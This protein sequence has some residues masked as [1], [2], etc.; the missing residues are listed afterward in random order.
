MTAKL[1]NEKGNILHRSSFRPVTKD[2]MGDPKER[3][4]RDTFDRKINPWPEYDI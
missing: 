3:E 2:E 1:L 4:K